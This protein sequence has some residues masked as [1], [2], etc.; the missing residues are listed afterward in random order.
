M[1]IGLKNLKNISV[2]EEKGAEIVKNLTSQKA[3]VCVDPTLLLSAN[4]WDEIIKKPEKM[5]KGKYIFTYFLGKYSK[6]RKKYIYD[7]AKENNLEVVNLGRLQYLKYYYIDPSEFLYLLKNSE[8][9]LTDSFHGS[10]FS[11]IYKKPFYIFERE[12]NIK[13]MNSRIETLLN[14]FDLKERKIKNYSNKISLDCDYSKI[15]DI[16]EKEKNKSMEFLKNSL[17]L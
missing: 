9:V 15:D 3:E 8:I 14:K 4:E 7:F 2:R 1:K 13:S 12:E 5:P 6:K 16:L 10:V 17:E 11:I